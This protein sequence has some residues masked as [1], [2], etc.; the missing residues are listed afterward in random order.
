MLCF[1]VI[2]FWQILPILITVKPEILSALNFGGSVWHYTLKIA[3][4]FKY[5]C[6]DANCQGCEIRE[7]MGT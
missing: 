3:R 5:F 7:I 4:D 1:A 2:S 6:E